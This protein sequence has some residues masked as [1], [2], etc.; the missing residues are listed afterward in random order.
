MILNIRIEDQNYPVDVPEEI[1][2]G[3]EDYFSM[4]DEDMSKGWQMSR[5]W[6]DEPDVQQRCQI[7]CDRILTAFD[8]DNRK[9]LIMY[10]AYILNRLP[11]VK[12]VNIA[13]TGEMQETEFEF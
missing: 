9:S 10:S 7:V 3:A 12:A 11:G 2:A 5:D 13:T 8:H 1:V 6:V 4:L